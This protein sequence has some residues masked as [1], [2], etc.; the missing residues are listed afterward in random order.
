M[1]DG[2]DGGRQFLGAG[3]AFPLTIDGH[4]Q[5]ATNGYDDHV[6][7]S[8]LLILQTAT[9]ERVMRPDFG[10]GL[11]ALVFEPVGATTLALVQHQ[12]KQTLMRYEPRIDVLEVRVAAPADQPGLL[13]I[14]LDYRVRD[15][16]TIAN[17][18][19]PFYIERSGA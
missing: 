1:S 9:G 11:R 2:A 10:A 15:T 13:E 17:L 16:D 8:I 14:E 4:G 6:R 19:Y 18:V 7:Q 12:V 3:M 5:V